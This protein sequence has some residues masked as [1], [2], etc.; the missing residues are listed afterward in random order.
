MR[1]DPKKALGRISK[2]IAGI[3]KALQDKAFN[4]VLKPLQGMA[5]DGGID[6]VSKGARENGL[7]K[8]LK[9]ITN[10]LGGGA[11]AGVGG[12]ILKRIPVLGILVDVALNKAGGLSWV[13]SI[14][15]GIAEGMGGMT[16]AATGYAIGSA[17]GGAAGALA[18]FG[19]GAIPGQMLGGALGAF[20]G[21]MVGAALARGTLNLGREA[22][23]QEAV[24][25]P[26]MPGSFSEAF[27]NL[28][29]SFS[30]D[31]GKSE[32]VKLNL[33]ATFDGTNSTPEGMNLP[34]GFGSSFNI[35]VTEMPPV[36]TKLTKK[37]E[38]LSQEVQNPP[39]LSATDS[40]MDPYRSLAL[41]K[42]QL[43]F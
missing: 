34:D 21:S 23:G 8:I 31:S 17:A 12:T 2:G 19:V 22:L 27:D 36:T 33:P 40:Q 28:K 25:A 3:G 41:T 32:A 4:T 29:G 26:D 16:G 38:D 39:A 24:S 11:L 1:G 43:A 10:K 42:Y 37:K 20:V 15:N 5:A 35:N 6:A 7:Q 30:S 9:P 14:I 13:N 18:G